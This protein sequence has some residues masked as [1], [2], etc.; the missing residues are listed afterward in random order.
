MKVPHW[1]SKHFRK[2]FRTV[3]ISSFALL[4]L[5]MIV[6]YAAFQHIS[7]SYLNT[8]MARFMDDAYSSVN[9]EM[10][11]SQV[12]CLKTHSSRSG[13]RLLTPNF[14][15]V[16][17]E[18]WAMK[19]IDC[20]ITQNPN[21]HS[22]LLYNAENDKIYMFGTELTFSD[23]HSFYDT[24]LRT[25]IESGRLFPHSFQ[26]RRIPHSPYNPQPVQVLT[27]VHSIGNG[28]FMIINLDVNELFSMLSPNSLSYEDDISNYLVF[29]DK[30]QTLYRSYSHS[31]LLSVGEKIQ[32]TLHEHHWTGSFN[33]FLDGRLYHFQVTEDPYRNLQMVSFVEHGDVSANFSTYLFTFLGIVFLVG[34]IAALVN[35]RISS[36]LYSP[37]DRIRSTLSED[38]TEEPSAPACEDEIEEIN[39]RISERTSKIQSLFSY[40]KQSQSIYQEN[41]LKSQL[42][43]DKYTDDEFWEKCEAEELPYKKGDSFVLVYAQWFPSCTESENQISDQGLICFALANV[44]HELFDQDV[45]VK[46]L[47]FDQNGIAFLFSFP[48]NA[49]PVVNSVLLSQVQT[50]FAQYFDLTLSFFLSS[51]FKKPR[52]MCSSM[53]ALQELSGYKFFHPSGCILYSDSFSSDELVTEICPSPDIARLEALIR[54]CEWP[55][56]STML[57]AW[58]ESLAG[59]T[60]EAA[61]TSITVFLSKLL[62]MFKRISSTCPSFPAINYYVFYNQVSSAY[63]LQQAQSLI[64]DQVREIILTIESGERSSSGLYAKNVQEFIDK[65]YSDPELSSKSIADQFHVSVAYLNRIFKQKTGESISSYIKLLRLEKAKKLLLETNKSVESI[66]KSVGFE[67]TKYFYP[68]FKNE[69]GISPNLFRTSVID[70][71]S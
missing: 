63:T 7:I 25:Q 6:L 40:K 20:F 31:E 49:S 1:Q 21:I 38:D 51:S 67:N 5:A 36:N 11:A 23:T 47:P 62:P 17:A 41:F 13:I 61:E 33:A 69:Y 64:S 24:E 3:Y 34:L 22:M 39:Q 4:L 71:D 12:L 45:T 66:A 14:N 56:C 70:S 18:F 19:D 44:I 28:N 10:D 27:A 9:K 53:Q 30:Q 37:I 29:Y 26:P 2:I 42:L 43:Q 54:T 15:D 32:Q 48:H 50:T 16:S 35:W 58:F 57:D 55:A 60:W 68:L 65:N 59:Y 46:D 8:V 52:S